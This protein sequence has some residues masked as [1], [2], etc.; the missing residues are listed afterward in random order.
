M[1]P[2]NEALIMQIKLENLSYRYRKGATDALEGLTAEIG[3]GMHLL[4]GENGAGKTTLLHLSDGLLTPTAGKCLIDGGPTQLRLASVLSRVIFMGPT[5]ELPAKDL[6]ELVR[7]HAQFYPNFSP[8]LLAENLK[9]F[10]LDPKTPFKSL[11]MGS[12]QKLRV[13]YALALRTDIV[14]LDEPATGLDIESKA[15]L[16][17]MVA[18]IIE[19]EQTVVV[20][21]HNVGDLERLFDGV[22]VLR[23][24][25]LVLAESVDEITR[26]YAFVT[27]PTVPTDAIY[28]EPT[29]GG[30]RAM[31]ENP[32]VE[33]DIDYRLLYMAFHSVGTHGSCVLS[34]NLRT[35]G[36][37]DRASLQN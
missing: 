17:R 31:L 6:D 29:I 11:S 10:G 14:L 1:R 15:E 3:P 18:R 20:A 19:P 35:L 26:R 21:T 24:G 12:L 33:T 34:P 22:L 25:Q 2:Y 7:T 28:A 37:T 32:D 36:R 16:Q 8:E 23:Q 30:F 27:L 13:A 5:T 4:M 9:A